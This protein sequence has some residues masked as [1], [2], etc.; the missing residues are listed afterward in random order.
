M[1]IV[2]V[3]YELLSFLFSMLFSCADI[4]KVLIPDQQK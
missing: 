1:L 2:E 4:N 3:K